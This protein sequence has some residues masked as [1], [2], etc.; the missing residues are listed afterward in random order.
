MKNDQLQAV[1]QAIQREN[2]D[3]EINASQPRILGR[4]RILEKIGQGATALVYRAFDPQLDRFLAIKVLR[5]RLAKDDNY[6]EAFLHE[7]RLAAQLSHPNIVTIFDV[8]IT[9]GKSYIAMELLEGA[10]LESLLKAKSKLPIKTVLAISSQLVSALVYAHQQGVVHRDIKP[11]NILILKGKKTT[12]LTDFG[13]AQASQNLANSNQP[14]DKVLGT[15]EY[16]SPEQILGKVVDAR[17][18]LY[19]TGVLMYRMLMGLAPFLSDDLGKLFTQIIKG[20]Q[21]EVLIDNENIQDDIKDLIRK[22]LQKRPEKRFQKAEELFLELKRII[23]KLAKNKKQKKSLFSSLTIRWTLSMAGTVF[24][25]MCIGLVVVYWMQYKALSGITFDYG[26]AVGRMIAYQSSEAV[27]LNDS[28]GLD[29]LI[30][31][32]AKNEQLNSIVIRDL[33]EKVLA[34]SFNAQVDKIFSLPKES[35]LLKKDNE[36]SIYKRKLTNEKIFFDIDMPI[37]FAEKKVGHLFVSFSADS[38]YKAS[39]TTLIMMLLVMLVTLVT[40]TIATIMLAKK[41]ANDYQRVTAGLIKMSVG[42]V[43]TKILSKRNDEASGLFSAFNQLSAYLERVFD[44][45]LDN[46]LKDDQKFEII[47]GSH[48]QKLDQKDIDTIELIVKEK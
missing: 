11:G 23:S 6:R 32:N 3:P 48:S 19:S 10:T 1:R 7:A 44:Q 39:N 36:V 14:T 2:S 16:M 8:G 9:D 15:P 29:V 34:S 27:V 38:L 22:L 13:I 42:R 24:V 28:V 41:T 43:G 30:E 5:D 25:S 18:D 33:S 4:Y 26:K 31:E 47:T 46:D 35:H 40:V 45:S 37:Y 17:S 20:K 21:P 12:K